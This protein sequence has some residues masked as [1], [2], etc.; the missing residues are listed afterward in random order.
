MF[1]AI[2][3]LTVAPIGNVH[4]FLVTC[5]LGYIFAG[6]RMTLVVLTFVIFF[7]FRYYPYKKFDRKEVLSLVTDFFGL[8]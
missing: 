8:F 3:F 7:G 4:P 6:L 1:D 5:A 2:L